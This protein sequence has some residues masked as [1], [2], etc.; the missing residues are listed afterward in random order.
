MTLSRC[1]SVE[2]VA[3]QVCLQSLPSL[4]PA[5]AAPLLTEAV[6]LQSLL[7]L[8]HALADN[9]SRLIKPKSI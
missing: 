5:L 3:P 7:S 1:N 9:I 2:L 4:L 6:C 8:L